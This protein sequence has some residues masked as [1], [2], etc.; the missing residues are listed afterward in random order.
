M[1]LDVLTAHLAT[2]IKAQS[3]LCY[4]SYAQ[5]LDD[6][7]SDIDLLVL[8]P[9]EIPSK[10]IR[11]SC[12]KNFSNTSIISL[13]KDMGDWD[14]SW[15]PV[16]DCVQIDNKRIDVGYNT[17]LWV[18]H[19][20]DNL[21]NKHQISFAEFSFRPYT[22]LGLLETAKILYDKDHFISSWLIK[23]KPMPLMLKKQI[24]QDFL[25][26]LKESRDEL[27]DYAARNIGILAYQFQLFRGLD[28]MVS[29]LFAINDTYDPASKRT[30]K[31]LLKLK[32][33]P[34]N[35]SQFI[36]LFL[37]RFYDYQQETIH[38]FDDCIHFIEN[39]E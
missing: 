26:I 24:I 20:I 2:Q 19:I 7:Q 18:N 12:Y 28:A 35:L 8:V 22:F 27:R 33:L 38:F 30:E 36:N 11:E 10:K 15:T 37:P 34:P 39:N 14:V 13:E 4:G 17:V 9:N 1:N 16:N 23:I 29:L 32:K 3:I 21:I 5:G 31:F 25:P 6:D